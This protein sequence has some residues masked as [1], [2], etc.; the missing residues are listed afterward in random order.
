LTD[1]GLVFDAFMFH[2]QLDDLVELARACPQA[3]IVLDH[4]GAPVGVGPYADKRSEVFADWSARMARLAECPNVTV[5]LGGFAMRITGFGFDRA[6]KAPCSDQ[7]TEA[8]QPYFDRV[9]QLFG[10]ERCMFESNFPVDKGSCSYTV[11]WNAYKKLTAKLPRAER[12]L[13][14]SGTAKRVYSL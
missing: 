3:S 9:V 10:A 6:E 8:W 13:L 5:K 7:L 2:P 14:L 12:C 4:Y 1:L 11:L